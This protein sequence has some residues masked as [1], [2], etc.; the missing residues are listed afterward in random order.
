MREMTGGERS[1]MV[2]IQNND[3]LRLAFYLASRCAVSPTWSEDEMAG[4]PPDVVDA[5][6]SAVMR[7]SDLLAEAGEEEKKT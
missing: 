3:H 2:R 6:T 4:E 1:E 7:L 5:I